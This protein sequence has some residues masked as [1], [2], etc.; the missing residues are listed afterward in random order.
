VTHYVP[1]SE[2]RALHKVSLLRQ[3]YPSQLGRD[4]WDDD[5]FLSLMRVRGMECR[6]RYAEG[7]VVEKATLS[8]CVAEE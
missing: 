4:W 1:V 5:L 6:T 7:F 2:E 8:W 3:C